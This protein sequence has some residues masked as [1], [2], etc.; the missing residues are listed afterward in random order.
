LES[1]FRLHLA[2]LLST[3]NA[4]TPMWVTFSWC[5]GGWKLESLGLEATSN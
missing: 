4:L 5:A 2:Q 3:S 1:L